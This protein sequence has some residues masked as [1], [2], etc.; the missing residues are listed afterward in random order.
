MKILNSDFES[1]HQFYLWT[2]S[3]MRAIDCQ[4]LQ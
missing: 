4:S 2:L 1:L 3:G